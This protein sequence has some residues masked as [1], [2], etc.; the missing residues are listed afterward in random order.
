MGCRE[1]KRTRV[2]V[3]Y[4]CYIKRGKGSLVPYCLDR[5]NYDSH[6]PDRLISVSILSSNHSFAT[7]AF[8]FELVAL[9]PKQKHPPKIS[10]L[11]EGFRLLPFL[12]WQSPFVPDPQFLL[13]ELASDGKTRIAWSASSCAFWF[14][15]LPY[16]NSRLTRSTTTVR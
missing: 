3:C 15:V 8:M 9:S 5:S 16:R 1:E 12:L 2:M 13:S 14:A 10:K 4:I 11:L 6:G 7:G